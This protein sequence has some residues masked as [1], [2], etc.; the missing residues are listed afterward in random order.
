MGQAAR[1][2]KKKKQRHGISRQQEERIRIDQLGPREGW[3]MMAPIPGEPPLDLAKPKL[4]RICSS[5]WLDACF[6]MIYERQTDGEEVATRMYDVRRSEAYCD[7]RTGQLVNDGGQCHRI[8]CRCCGVFTPISGYAERTV[9]TKAICPKCGAECGNRLRCYRCG[10]QFAA[11]DYVKTCL[12]RDC[13]ISGADLEQR[14]AE[15]GERAPGRLRAEA[16]KIQR[17]QDRWGQSPWHRFMAYMRLMQVRL[18]WD[19]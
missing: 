2:K 19:K 4:P 5:A 13:A 12:C 7:P 11:V 3:G 17:L 16:R 10:H 18:P 15:P 14:A 1:K 9:D 6:W 8:L